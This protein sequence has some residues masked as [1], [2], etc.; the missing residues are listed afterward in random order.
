[1]LKIESIRLTPRAARRSPERAARRSRAAWIAARNWAAFS[2]DVVVDDDDASVSLS[3]LPRR[4]TRWRSSRHRITAAVMQNAVCVQME[5]SSV[6]A[7]RSCSRNIVI[8][9]ET[10]VCRVYA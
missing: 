5:I 4:S 8:A 2:S 6:R 10:H 1:M 3:F 9:A 7:I